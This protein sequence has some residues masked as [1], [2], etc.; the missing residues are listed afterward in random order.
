MKLMLVLTVVQSFKNPKNIRDP[1]YCPLK[2]SGILP[3]FAGLRGLHLRFKQLKSWKVGVYVNQ[4]CL[5]KK[6]KQAIYLFSDHK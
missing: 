2:M 3:Y 1:G 6:S 4:A 5:Q